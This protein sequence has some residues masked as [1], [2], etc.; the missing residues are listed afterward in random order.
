MP[1]YLFH[2]GP[3]KTGSTYLQ[4]SFDKSRSALAASGILYPEQWQD[5]VGHFG[6]V[7]RLRFLDP[8]LRLEFA[9]LNESSIKMVLLSAEDLSDLPKESLEFLKQC[10]GHNEVTIIFYCRRWSELLA[11]GWQEMVKHGETQTLP[12]F[13]AGHM[14]NPYASHIVN[15]ARRLQSFTEVFGRESLRLVSYSHLM[16]NGEDILYHFMYSFLPISNPPRPERVILNA[17]MGIL[18]TELV[19]ALNALV[20]AHGGPRS[21][22]A[23]QNFVRAKPNLE[24]EP[25]FQAMERAKRSIRLHEATGSVLEMHQRLAT[26]YGALMVPPKPSVLLFCPRVSEIPYIGLDYLMGEDIMGLYRNLRSVLQL[27]AA[28][29][30]QEQQKKHSG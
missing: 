30:G 12:E 6:L 26:E 8:A 2:V 19:R 10:V 4:K 14:V 24:L 1:T 25:F 13:V 15:Y 20:W 17:S 21:S 3:H 7:R 9:E 11:S 29:V 22:L 23:Y 16:D 18:E 27:E 5:G 28:L